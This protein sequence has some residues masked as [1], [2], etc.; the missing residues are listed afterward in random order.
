MSNIMKRVF[1]RV[2]GVC[3]YRDTTHQSTG[4]FKHIQSL[5]VSFQ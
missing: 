4:A 2:D 1:F 3:Q 5:R